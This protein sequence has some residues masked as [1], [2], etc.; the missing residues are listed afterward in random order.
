[1]PGVQKGAL[2]FAIGTVALMVVV[3]GAVGIN[4]LLS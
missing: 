3:F 2:W 4:A 1:M